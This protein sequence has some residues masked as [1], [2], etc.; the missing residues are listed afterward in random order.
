MCD[1]AAKGCGGGVIRVQ[2]QGVVVTG[3]GGKAA[4]VLQGDRVA[5]LGLLPEAQLIKG[6]IV[7][8]GHAGILRDC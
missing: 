4:Q 1:A 2:M 5:A 6:V 3:C 7:Y 8:L